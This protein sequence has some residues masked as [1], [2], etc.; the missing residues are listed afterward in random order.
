MNEGGLN[1]RQI[2]GWVANRFYYQENIRVKTPLSSP[3]APTVRYA[4]A[5]SGASTTM[6]ARQ[7]GRG[8][9]RPGYAWARLRD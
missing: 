3:T 5:G 2:Q 6:M 1:R 4:D 8:A 7:T 9:S